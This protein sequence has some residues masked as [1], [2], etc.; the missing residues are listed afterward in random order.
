MDYMENRST[1]IHN[2]S[3]EESVLIKQ[4][5][6]EEMNHSTK[7]RL[8]YLRSHT[9]CPMFANYHPV[10]QPVERLFICNAVLNTTHL[11]P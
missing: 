8:W 7:E 6:G 4:G 3:T 11:V 9:E 5:V 10:S 1:H 2:Y